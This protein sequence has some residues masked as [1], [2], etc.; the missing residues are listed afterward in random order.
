MEVHR[1]IVANIHRGV[2]PA[3]DGGGA[4]ASKNGLAR[5]AATQLNVNKKVHLIHHDYIAT[6]KT[7]IINR[8]TTKPSCIEA[9]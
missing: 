2:T 5:T 4:R 6:R 7:R 1:S 8:N 9:Q 3:E